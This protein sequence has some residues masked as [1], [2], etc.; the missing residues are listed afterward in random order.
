MKIEDVL[1]LRPLDKYGNWGLKVKNSIQTRDSM[2]RLRGRD[3][4]LTTPRYAARPGESNEERTARMAATDPGRIWN[5]VL[6]PLLDAMDSRTRDEVL[7][8]LAEY[9]NKL[10]SS[11]AS[12]GPAGSLTFT[13]RVRPEREFDLSTSAT[14][15]D[16]NKAGEKFWSER[17]GKPL[18][19]DHAGR[20][21]S[22]RATPASIQRANDAFWNARNAEQNSSAR[23]WGG[24]KG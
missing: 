16:I 15:D 4:L 7:T 11:E 14:P 18:T 12:P 6:K 24:G 2:P 21:L 22:T 13:G 8:N 23:P 3:M 5:G 9:G 10:G 1:E 19:Q 17:M 20:G